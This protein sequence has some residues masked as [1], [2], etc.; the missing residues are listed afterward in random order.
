[1]DR[2]TIQALKPIKSLNVSQFTVCQ[3]EARNDVLRRIGEEP[4]RE[5]FLRQLSWRAVMQPNDI[6]GVILFLV[7]LSISL[8][9]MITFTGSLAK[10]SFDAVTDTNGGIFLVLQTWVIAHQLAFFAFSELGVL[11]FYIR[12]SMGYIRWRDARIAQGEQ[13]VVER[14]RRHRWFSVASFAAFACAIV[15]IIANVT[16]LTH[17]IEDAWTLAISGGIGFLIPILTLFLGER[18]AEI[19][20]DYLYAK[21]KADNEFTAAHTQWQFIR[22][23]PEKF[24]EQDKLNSYRRYLAGRIVQYYRKNI[25][26][27]LEINESFEWTPEMELALAAR[28]LAR[29]HRMEDLEAAEAFFMQPPSEE[30][31]PPKSTTSSDSL[32]LLPNV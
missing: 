14:D 21:E 20:M 5:D 1:M 8:I 32:Q 6:F 29:L 26:P 31:S 22:Q 9:H 10:A 25:I 15:A 28:E 16:S 19:L 3:E 27:R 23:N 30:A 17:G 11:F 7:L 24:D 2:A 4:R 18:A 13:D 12:H